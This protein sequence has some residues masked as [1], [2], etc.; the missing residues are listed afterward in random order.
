M[1]NIPNLIA[2]VAL[3]LSCAACG[4]FLEEYPNDQSYVINTEDLNELLVGDGYMAA[5]SGADIGYWIHV[6]DDDVLF[7]T[8]NTNRAAGTPFYW[9]QPDADTRSTWDALYKHIG[10][11]NAVLEEVEQ[12]R[13]EPGDGYRKVKGEALFLRAGYYYYLVNLYGL[14]YRASATDPGVPLKLTSTI[15]D[16]RFARNSVEECYRA[17]TADLRASIACL[18]GIVPSTTYR[19]SE[20][21]ARALLSRVALY[22]HDWETAR[23]QCDSVLISGRYRLVDHNMEGGAAASNTVAFN[24]NDMIFTS[25]IATTTSG[26]DF[27][28]INATKFQP[29]AELLAT[30]LDN[31]LRKT[32]YVRGM[33]LPGYQVIQKSVSR[34]VAMCSDIF[35]LRLPEV[36]LN[37]AEALIMLDREADAT[38][39]LQSLLAC[40][41][42]VP[43]AINLSGAALM[44]FLRDERRREFCYEG[45]RWFDLR[46]YAVYPTYPFQKEIRHPYYEYVTVSG[47]M[48]LGKFDDE[49][50][51]YV[52]SLPENE[53]VLN[54]G[55]LAQNPI[56]AWKEEQ[57]HQ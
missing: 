32:Y 45:Q 40:R 48:V 46:R 20:M 1:K 4:D 10:V 27:Q 12:F 3:C 33:P 26:M 44:D 49:P 56:R 7:V 8:S 21:A 53:I 9:W 29:S 16:R 42:S 37:R 24:S 43:L 54:G 35:V 14:P 41:L 11:L 5:T 52:L 57:P 15:E 39:D 6:M 31:D 17:I 19:A 47:D 51:Y 38:A 22:T 30:F 23:V 50:Q 25:G 36:Y 13:D 28:Y 55:V 34:I 18:K 2:G